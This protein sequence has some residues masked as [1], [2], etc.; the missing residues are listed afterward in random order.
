MGRARKAK[1]VLETTRDA[2]AGWRR[3]YGGRGRRI[4]AAFWNEARELARVHGVAETAR[5]LRLDPGRLAAVVGQ[6]LSIAPSSVEPEAFV[7]V[8]G[9]QF[10]ER[11][12]AAV[13]EFLGREGQCVRVQIAASAV[14]VTALAAAFWSRRP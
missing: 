7:E 9:L 4:P 10:G 5:E 6:T 2:L 11:G 13:V 8:G 12:G 3:Q 1:T 14:D